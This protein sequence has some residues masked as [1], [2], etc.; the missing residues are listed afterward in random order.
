MA[1]INQ[2]DKFI[3]LSKRQSSFVDDK[4]GEFKEYKYVSGFNPV[5][6]QVINDLTV[7]EKGEGAIKYDDIAELGAYDVKYV[8]RA[9]KNKANSLTISQVRFLKKFGELELKTFK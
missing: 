7:D 6:S 5:T 1:L 4:T 3:V 9:D 8:T 2:T